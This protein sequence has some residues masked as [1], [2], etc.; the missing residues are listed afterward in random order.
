MPAPRTI[1]YQTS[2]VPNRSIMDVGNELSAEISRILQSP[3]VPCLKVRPLRGSPAGD[4]RFE[5]HE[6]AMYFLKRLIAWLGC[7]RNYMT[8]FRMPIFEQS[9]TGLF[10]NHVRSRVWLMQSSTDFSLGRLCYIFYKCCVCLVQSSVS[11]RF[12]LAEAC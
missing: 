12:A 4:T 6:A 10:A 8:S 7:N 2:K 1:G 11:L 9:R 3:Y 5:Y